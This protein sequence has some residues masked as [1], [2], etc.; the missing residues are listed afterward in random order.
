MPVKG[1][2]FKSNSFRD[3]P[4]LKTASRGERLQRK[5]EVLPQF[6]FNDG[7]IIKIIG[8]FFLVV[9]LYFLVAFTSYLFTWNEDQSYVLDANGGW[10]NLFKTQEEL[11]ELGLKNPVVEN[12]L[13]KFGALLSHQFIYEWFGIASFIFIGVFFIIGYRLLFKVKLFSV[14]KTF[15]YSFFLLIFL[16]LT[17]A[18]LHSFLAEAV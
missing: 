17:F 9:S 13:G 11:Q 1:N 2:Q 14:S 18:F 5:A 16:S 7:R 10:S 4:K 15:G 3:E 12:W 6:S 8:L